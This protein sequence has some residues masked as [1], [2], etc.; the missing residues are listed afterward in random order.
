[1]QTQNYKLNFAGQNIYVGFD[2]HKADWTVSIIHE[3]IMCKTFTQPPSPTILSSYLKKNY[4]GANYF[5]AYEASFCG[6]WIHKE[7]IKLGIKNIVVNPAD[8]PTSDKERKQKEDRRDSRK[9]ARELANGNLKGIYVPSNETLEDR[10]LV[11]AREKLI[12]DL[13]RNKNRIKSML[14]F[15]GIEYP[16]EFLKNSHWSN[17][18]VQWIESIRFE[19]ESGNNAKDILLSQFKNLRKDVLLLT[20][21]IRKLSRTD[22]YKKN[23]ELL[24]SIPGISTLSAMI[25]ITEIDSIDRF[26]NFDNFCSFVGLIPSTA[27]TGDKEITRG[28]TP[29]RSRVLR[30]IIV[31]NSW[32]AIRHE[33]VLSLYY[34]ETAK[35]MKSNRAIIRVAR[36]FLS[37]IYCVLRKGQKYEYG[38]LK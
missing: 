25:L 31:E 10:S 30:S 3:S 1:M 11:R 15:Y 29:R 23:V 37:R 2:S 34:T 27:S 5:S 16:Q 8:I 4:P 9:I 32:I 33:P 6:F 21:G 14:Y 17:K 28:I 18:F 26:P 12:K 36:K 35:R 19:N 38:I 22:K 13:T 24:I 7:L 20:K